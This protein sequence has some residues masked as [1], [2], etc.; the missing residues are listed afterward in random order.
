MQEEA[1]HKQIKL[2]KESEY[3][4]KSFMKDEMESVRKLKEKHLKL[5]EEKIRIN[6]QLSALRSSILDEEYSIRGLKN[7]IDVRYL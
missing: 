5:E 1:L 3:L 4:L 6:E 2:E 7:D